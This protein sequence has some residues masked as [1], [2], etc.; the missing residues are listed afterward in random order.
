MEVKVNAF[1]AKRKEKCLREKTPECEERLGSAIKV[2]FT[3]KT[4]IYIYMA[5]FPKMGDFRNC[6]NQQTTT[7]VISCDPQSSILKCYVLYHDHLNASS[8][9]FLK[10]CCEQSKWFSRGHPQ[11]RSRPIAS[12]T[13]R[14]V[15]EWTFRWF[16]TLGFQSTLDFKPAQL[17]MCGVIAMACS[18]W[19]LSKLQVCEQDKWLL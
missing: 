3:S 6:L 15:S 16:Q 11:P 2:E 19:A 5:Y 18:H 17:T 9:N 4:Y 7:E 8:W 13:P 12:F 1:Q 10:I 14:H